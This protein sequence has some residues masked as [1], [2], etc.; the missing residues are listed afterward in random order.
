MIP[1]NV[2]FNDDRSKKSLT[3][4]E[5]KYDNDFI[6]RNF[7]REG[8]ILERNIFNNNYINFLYNCKKN[9]INCENYILDHLNK[10][11]IKAK[12]N[13]MPK[14]EKYAINLLQL[15]Y[16]NKINFFDVFEEKETIKLLYMSLLWNNSH[17]IEEENIKFYFSP[18]TKRLR[19]CDNIF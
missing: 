1:L 6:Q 3:I 19:W 17:H 16:Q 9:K 10:L 8:L 2:S 15:Y 7:L 12:K 13:N 4:L 18:I 5:E 14:Q 11:H